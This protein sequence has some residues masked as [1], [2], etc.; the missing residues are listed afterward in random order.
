MFRWRYLCFGEGVGFLP[1]DRRQETWLQGREEGDGEAQTGC[2]L[3]G[4]GGS[5]GASSV[6]LCCDRWGG[7]A[8]GE[9]GQRPGGEGREGKRPVGGAGLCGVGA[10]AWVSDAGLGAGRVREVWVG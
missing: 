10:E 9:R 2:R 1:V 7:T 4:V 8:E 5:L 3:P 6:W